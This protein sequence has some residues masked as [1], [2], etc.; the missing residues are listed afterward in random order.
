MIDMGE[1]VMSIFRH[2]VTNTSKLIILLQFKCFKTRRKVRELLPSLVRI[3][4]NTPRGVER[5]PGQLRVRVC[6]GAEPAQGR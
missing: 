5:I 6:T 2:T 4:A 1:F 3:E